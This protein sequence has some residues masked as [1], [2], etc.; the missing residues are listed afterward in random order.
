M[1]RRPGF[2]FLELIV[3]L[4][5]ILLVAALMFPVFARTRESAR[6]TT[7]QSNLRQIGTA[8]LL[9]AQDNNG[10]LPSAEASPHW[11]GAVMPQVKN[12]GVFLCP[13]EPLPSR[14]YADIVARPE[15]VSYQYQAGLSNDDP[16]SSPVARDWD[17]WHFD[18]V[19][20]LLLEGR[21]EWMPGDRAPLARAPRPAAAGK[22]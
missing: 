10:R 20:V 1:R 14:R 6:R 2:T 12:I 17:P 21:I 7:C 5:I 18:G 16:G 8:L 4:T 13:S 22:E 11:V 9:Y 15:S 3:T 19:N